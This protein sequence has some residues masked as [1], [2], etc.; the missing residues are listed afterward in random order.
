MEMEGSQAELSRR[1]AC[2]LQD[3]RELLERGRERRRAG[4]P[5]RQKSASRLGHRSS[6]IPIPPARCPFTIS[7]LGEGSPTKKRLQKKGKTLVLT[8][9]L[10]DLVHLSLLC[11]LLGGGGP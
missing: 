4:R 1:Q 11:F 9:L 5:K 3:L 2:G 8:S 7:F 6:E 10:E